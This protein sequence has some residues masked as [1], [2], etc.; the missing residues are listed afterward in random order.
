[1]SGRFTPSNEHKT[2]L[3]SG[4]ARAG[5]AKRR[6]E[7]VH[8]TSGSADEINRLSIATVAETVAIYTM[9]PGQMVGDLAERDGFGTSVI[10]A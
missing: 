1:M 6:K 9:S 4:A 2:L 10:H 8:S 3:R 7:P 5:L